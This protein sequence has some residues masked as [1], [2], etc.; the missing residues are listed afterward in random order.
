V[1]IKDELAVLSLVKI[2]VLNHEIISSLA[3]SEQ[4]KNII[5]YTLIEHWTQ[6]HSELWWLDSERIIDTVVLIC[7]SRE[8]SYE[9]TSVTKPKS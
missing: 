8:I 5:L 6:R 7:Q 2:V 1:K 4:L 9:T 3:A